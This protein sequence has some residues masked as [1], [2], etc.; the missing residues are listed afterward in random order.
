MNKEQLD[1]ITGGAEVPAG[2]LSPLQVAA[3]LE[4]IGVSKKREK[5][6]RI[7]A[8]KIVQLYE[9][10]KSESS[11]FNIL[12]SNTDT[13]SPA[14]YNNTPR[15]AVTRRFQD[16]DPLGAAVCMTL[17]RTLVYSLDSNDLD[18]PEFDIL[19]EHAILQAL[20][21]GRGV[22]RFKYNADITK[23]G[24]VKA[25]EDQ[26]PKTI[27]DTPAEGYAA[28]TSE[29]YEKVENERICGE[30]VQ[31]DR[32]LCG[33][34]QKWAQV[35]WISF[36]HHMTEAELC[37]NFGDEI[38]KKVKCAELEEDSEGE[39]NAAKDKRKVAVVYEL[40][41]KADR[42]VLFV[43][44]GYKDRELKITE[45]PL[46]LSGFY[47]MDEPLRFMN[48]V[49]NTIPQPIYNLYRK[50]AEELNKVTNRIDAIIE[51]L[52]VRGAYDSAVTEMSKI[53]AADDGEM[54]AIENVQMLGEGADL[55]KAIFLMP[56]TELVS[57]LQQLYLQRTQVK[58]VIYEITG[59]S[60]ILRGSSVASETA[61]AQ[62]IK[63]DWGTL[64]LKKS[65]K[66]V[67]KWCRN[68]LRIMAEIAARKFSQ[69]TFMKVTE[70]PY[71]TMEQKQAAE[72]ELTQWKQQQMMQQQ[73]AQ[74]AAAMQPQPQPEQPPAP[75]P[76]QAPPQ[77][78]PQHLVDM[79]ATP[80]WEEI[81]ALMRDELHMSYRVDIETNSTIAD[82]MAEDQK[83][84]GELLNALSQF[85]NGVAPLIE[86]KTMPFEVAK[87]M[88][89][90]I[91]RKMRMGPEVEDLLD[92]MK[93]PEPPAAPPPP[94]PPPP[95]PNIQ[96]KAQ[97]EAAKLQMEMQRLKQ[98]EEM[99]KLEM[100]AA[101]QEHTNKMTLENQKM[102]VN[103]QKFE[104]QMALAKQKAMTPVS[105]PVT[106]E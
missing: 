61:T 79:M 52:K 102:Q 45:D 87:A 104:T 4:E 78:P 103:Q 93:E 90:G 36:E 83:N 9:G 66:K 19:A 18:Q 94:P 71:I 56:L 80:V 3:W 25:A 53:L 74:Q 41:N 76:P 33:Y 49:S 38:G 22:I 68:N 32:F 51:C 101:R 96:L 43:S 20:V 70:L 8:A 89:L 59:I 42:T 23:A 106:A 14:L 57:V 54:V 6:W 60:D 27:P 48:K 58:T 12:F 55:K 11:P 67:Q 62:T 13:M 35:P 39:D 77:A 99:L 86:G 81:I 7:E 28:Q 1:K 15:P 2:K 95:D 100:E 75:V 30:M 16:K 85:L 64:R 21:P 91:V 63:N 72:A 82:D 10:Y 37:K 44:P 29:E 92:K 69:E 105:H 88:M 34:A 97:A 17:N 50:Q 26:N 73:Q 47:P 65:Q 5:S 24:G 98:E 46:E 84:I 31:Y 40:W